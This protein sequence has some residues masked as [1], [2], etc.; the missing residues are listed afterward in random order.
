LIAASS[1]SLLSGL[2]SPIAF[3]QTAPHLGT[4][5]VLPPPAAPFEGTLG[6]TIGTS[7]PP[8]YPAPPTAPKGAPNV[9]LIMTD[10]V[11]FAASSTF[12]GPIPTPTFD[13]LAAHG[14]RYN[15]F[16][17]TALCSPT[18]AALLTGRNHHSVG[19]GVI[20]ELATGYPGYNSIIPKSAA[21]IGEV[22]RQNG[23]S[24]SWFG[25]NH[26]TPDWE[27]T[28]IGPYDRWPNGMGFDYFYGF[29]GG[30][31]NQWA[32]T[33]TENR[34]AV[35]PPHDDPTYNLDKDLADHAINWL[36]VQ[37]TIAPDKPFLMYFAPG[38]SHAPH[39][40]PKAWIAKFKGQFDQGWDKLREESFARQKKAGVIPANAELTPRPPEIPAWDSLSP[41]QK[42]VEAHMME[43]YA[44]ALSYCD[45]EM[46][47][48]LQALRDSG[49]IDNTIIIY[50]QGDNG[51]SAEG[52]LGGTTNDLN[53]LNGVSE[54]FAYTKTRVADMGG[55][56]TAS[57]YPVG[58]AWAMDAPFQWTKQI[59]SHFGGT[60]NGMV[61]S[62]PGHIK[63]EG[64]LRSQFSSV[65][66]IAPTLYDVIGITPPTE[67]NGVE[68]KPLEGS[69][70]AY[71]FNA[72]DAPTHH[73]E[74]YFEMLANRAIYKDGWMASTHP[75]RLP[76][77]PSIAHYDPDSYTWELYHVADDYSQAHD[78]AAQ[79]P[80]KLAEMK[81]EFYKEAAKYQVLPIDTRTIERTA[82]SA[83]PSNMNGREHITYYP[84]PARYGPGAWPDL[85]NRSWSLS[86][87][88]E[89]TKSDASGMIVTEG[90]RF[91]GWGLMLFDGKPCFI[92]KHSMQA[93]DMLRIDAAKALAPGKHKL[94]LTFTSDAPFGFGI[95]ATAVLSVDGV[96]AAKGHIA[97]TTRAFMSTDGAAIGHDTGTPLIDDYRLPFAF[98]GTI[99]QVD[100][101]LPKHGAGQERTAEEKAALAVA[102]D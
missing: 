78:L 17:T 38:T 20:E 100:F 84:G 59:A 40:A 33:L 79:Q 57:H 27:N 72:P 60:R 101:Y 43:V 75:K 65:I 80:A 30:E 9:L 31:T 94:E 19:A 58:W 34:N 29:M 95:G 25:K 90:G 50:I 92:Y 66:D 32:P 10:D 42:A 70:L 96:E 102:A 26:N 46:G 52:T 49:Q 83:R 3:A 97:A 24:T 76:W 14:L 64:G 67:V 98:E 1:L 63:Q 41:E 36:H 86:T 81:E 11:G 71:S 62:W 16:H 69:S 88:I 2:G 77:S 37:H 51:A 23:Y 39:D 55:P 56:Q 91:A 93:P 74:Q 15:E 45:D 35:E 68:Q 18:R 61:V 8:H 6:R 89:V 44:A 12:G 85:R 48:V 54:P 47:R 87:E 53:A 5:A 7:S 21:T 28:P 73:R 99:K 22:L 4:S 13:N 82:Q